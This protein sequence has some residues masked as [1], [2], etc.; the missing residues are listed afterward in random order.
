MPQIR[1][2]HML[3]ALMKS[4]G[5]TNRALADDAALCIS[6]I[7]HLRR[8]ARTYATPDTAVAIEEAL[9]VP[10]GSIFCPT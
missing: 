4:L 10:A 7:A 1:S 3:D 9:D 2:H 5:A 8:G 6:T